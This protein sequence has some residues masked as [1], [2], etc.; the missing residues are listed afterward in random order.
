[1]LASMKPLHL[2]TDS[3]LQRLRLSRNVAGFKHD[4]TPGR[5]K[6]ALREASALLDASAELT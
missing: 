6:W 3:S 1:M 2:A 4:T 5:V